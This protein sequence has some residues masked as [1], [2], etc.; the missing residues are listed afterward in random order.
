MSRQPNG[1][2]IG[3]ENITDNTTASGVY[4]LSDVAQKVANNEFPPARFT[5]SRSLRFASERSAYLSR[6]PSTS[7]NRTTWTWS[8]WVKNAV[9]NTQLFGV[10]S[11]VGTSSTQENE[12][13]SIQLGTTFDFYELSGG[14]FVSQKYLQPVFRDPS[15]WYHL[16]VAV[17]YTQTV[18]DNRIK[19]YV[20]GVHQVNYRATTTPAQNRTSFMNGSGNNHT[21][22]GQIKQFNNFFDAYVTEIN[23]IDG[24]QL[25]PS[26][27]GETDS[28]T[29]EWKPKRYTGSYGTNG[30]YLSF[31]NNSSTSTLGLDDGTGLP[32]SGAGS[33]DW[34]ANNFS[35]TAGTGN[36]SLVDVPGVGSP[37][38]ND[39]GGVT[40]GNY[41]TWNPLYRVSSTMSDA[42]LKSSATSSNT[43][44]VTTFPMPTT[45]KWYSELTINVSPNIYWPMNMGA[46]DGIQGNTYCRLYTDWSAFAIFK[47]ING[48]TSNVT[49]SGSFPAN[50]DILKIAYD[51]D[52]GKL[53]LGLNSNWYGN[54]GSL[55]GNPTTGI[56][57]TLSGILGKEIYPNHSN[58]GGPAQNCW[59]NAGQRPFSY[60]PPTGFKSLCTTN[61]PEP[62]VK[63]PKE[64]FDIKTWVG[65]QQS[66][67]IG[68]TTRER[69]NYEINK[70]LRS[71]IIASSFLTR[72]PTT[73][74]NRKTWTW[75]GWVKRGTTGAFQTLF[76]TRGA[77]PGDTNTLQFGFGSSDVF[78]LGLETAFFL[79]SKTVFDTSNWYHIV[80]ALDTT[81]SSA[82]NRLRV[83]VNG[84]ELTSWSTDSRSSIA[85]NSDL[86]INIANQLHQI[87]TLLSNS[88]F[89]DGYLAEINFVDG[90]ALT[91]ESFG[92]YDIDGSWQAKRYTGTYG[93]NGFYLKLDPDYNPSPAPVG[94]FS[95]DFVVVAGGGGGSATLGGG[96][97]AGGF[98]TSAGTSGS[99]NDAEDPVGIILGTPYTITV[100]AGGNGGAGSVN[101]G[102]QGSNSIFAS[103]VSIGGGAGDGATGGAAGWLGS[104]IGIGG[105]GGGSSSTYNGGG[106]VV[107]HGAHGG[108]GR[109][110]SGGL[111][112]G[113][114]YNSGGGGGA[115]AAG[116]NSTSAK[117]GNGGAGRSTTISGSSVFYAGGGGGGNDSARVNGPATGGVG[118]G[119]NSNY[120]A[121]GSNAT[122]NTG[123]GGGGGSNRVGGG[124]GYNGGNGG[125]GI[126]VIKIPNTRTATFSGGVTSSLS[127][128]VSGYKVYTVTA[129]ST[130]SET[131]T[132]S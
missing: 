71:R 46:S 21:I 25:T 116:E 29:G 58:A 90:Q 24:Q 34:T 85:L 99:G 47:S 36:D 35:V 27:F 101:N 76:G 28:R 129:T 7:S 53:W 61:L 109:A 37:V 107:G 51:A 40:R 1:G 2:F 65:N 8:A 18:G 22:G 84:S 130:T 113:D 32:G 23:F 54:S 89:L 93:T 44:V 12:R 33:N 123:G 103:I 86:G 117:G 75:S 67:T 38:T 98:R 108:K 70:S 82:I 62:A 105:S 60:T 128:A 112:S 114:G 56:D 81:Q 6:V 94:D 66:L 45:G 42:N 13:L 74:G 9:G 104:S 91:P 110:G 15:A 19:M 48:V 5:P 10:T 39:I 127:T 95:A 68:N 120:N 11:G 126:I 3:K 57:P 106:G 87:G 43:N 111:N 80:V 97:G 64:Y 4:T 102:V 124:A 52:A 122:A 63:N 30:Y 77:S 78:Q 92:A 16:I 14:S 83:Y 118:G 20:N 59:L 115:A 131:V 26:S 88:W 119:G 17:D 49:P 96:G 73:A 31:A 132:F 41:A 72:I 121:A 69:D 55:T 79:S 50:G 125:S 100:G